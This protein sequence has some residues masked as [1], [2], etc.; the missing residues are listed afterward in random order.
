MRCSTTFASERF[1]TGRRLDG[2]CH[3]DSESSTYLCAANYEFHRQFEQLGVDCTFFDVTVTNHIHMLHAERAGK[4]DQAILDSSFPSATLAFRPP[5]RAE[6]AVEQS[7]AGAMGLDELGAVPAAHRPRHRS[8][9][10]RELAALASLSLRESAPPLAIGRFR[11]T[12][13]RGLRRQRPRWHSPILRSRSSPSRSPA[14]AGC[15]RWCSEDSTACIFPSSS[16]SPAITPCMFLRAPGLPPFCS[17]RDGHLQ[18]AVIR[19]V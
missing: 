18:F 2:E 15:W 11:G 6:I 10:R 14:D 1:E 17:S 13:R 19:P 12:L 4:S 5:T 8:A 16:A 9:N 3:A 7:G